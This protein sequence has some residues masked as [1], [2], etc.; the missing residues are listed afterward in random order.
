[1]N[2]R[3][4]IP[5]N[6]LKNKLKTESCEKLIIGTFGMKFFNELADFRTEKCGTIRHTSI[7]LSYIKSINNKLNLAGKKHSYLPTGIICSEIQ[8]TDQ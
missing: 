1:M 4:N 3:G 8:G 2:V 5:V 7:G 6:G